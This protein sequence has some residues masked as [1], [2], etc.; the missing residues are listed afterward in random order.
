M[1]YGIY[2]PSRRISIPLNETLRYAGMPDCQKEALIFIAEDVIRTCEEKMQPGL[3]YRICEISSIESN[4]VILDNG[5]CLTGSLVA[6]YLV[7][8]SQVCVLVG[9][10]G[11][12]VDR[13]ISA[14]SYKSSVEGLL[15]D[16]AGSAAIEAVV[17]DFCDRISEKCRSK[18]R[19]SPGYGDFPLTNQ[20]VIF[21]LLDATKS[22]GTCL[23][24]SLLISP[25]K[26]VTALVGLFG[27]HHV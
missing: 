24:D 13:V 14:Y 22:I 23:N 20:S 3:V 19:I 9:T 17:D 25:S 8:C 15:A 6:K 16:A 18:P 10:V 12:S 11:L 26:S 27:E 21:S 2:R 1:K 5:T 4:R 7:G